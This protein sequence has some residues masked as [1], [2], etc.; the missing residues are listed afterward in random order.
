MT[1]FKDKGKGQEAVRV[2]LFTYPVLMAA[3]I[4]LYDADRG[5]RRRR[6]APAPGADPGGGH[7]LQ[8]PLRRDLR[9]PRGRHPRHGR[10]GHGPPAPR[11][12]DVQVGRLAARDD[13]A[14]R[15]G[16]G[17]HAQG[18]QGGHRHR[19][20]DALR[21]RGQAGPGQPARA[22]GR[23]NGPDAHGARGR[24]HHATATSRTTWRRRSASCCGRSASAAGPST[25]TWPTSTRCSIG[26]PARAHAVA[27]TTYARAADAMGL[28]PEPAG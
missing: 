24:L 21:P 27:S 12:Q 22:P 8:P 16:R 6:P 3:D 9:R 15:L 13:R 5:A 25:A 11:A 1:Q 28:L 10:P 4:L 26:A 19:R 17:D 14:A 20:R 7:P 23:G 2:G 18:A